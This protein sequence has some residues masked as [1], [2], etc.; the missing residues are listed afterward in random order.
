M[1]A[2]RVPCTAGRQPTLRDGPVNCRESAQL[3]IESKIAANAIPY[4]LVPLP[5]GG[6]YSLWLL[7]S[8]G[9]KAFSMSNDLTVAAHRIAWRLTHNA[10]AN[11]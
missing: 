5:S 2:I 7:I 9:S 8:A 1:L 3:N 6:Y 11:L 4:Y 10:F